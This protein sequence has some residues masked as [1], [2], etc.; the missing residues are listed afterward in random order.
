[1]HLRTARLILFNAHTKYASSSPRHLQPYLE[2]QN[3]SVTKKV[4]HNRLLSD[5]DT[6]DA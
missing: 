5:L 4:T 3:V 1:M 6:H 2:E